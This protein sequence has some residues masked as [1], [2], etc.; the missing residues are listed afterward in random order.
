MTVCAEVLRGDRD[1]GE[2]ACGC[3]GKGCG[4][5]NGACV[6]LAA[7]EAWVELVLWRAMSRCA[8]LVCVARP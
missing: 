4:V 1:G 7:C 6:V 5:A 8:G 2:G 3:E